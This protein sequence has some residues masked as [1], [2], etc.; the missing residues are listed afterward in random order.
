[1]NGIRTRDRGWLRALNTVE[2]PAGRLVCLPYSGGSAATYRAWPSA[3]PA[4]LSLLAVQYPGHADRLAEPLAGSVAELGAGVAADL[5]RLD[6]APCAL[7]G[8]SL[9]ALVAYEAARVLQEHG[10]PVRALFP[11][12]APAPSQHR[13]GI[14]HEAGEEELWGALC[15]LGGMDPAV[16]RDSELRDLMLPV[17]RA[18]I[19]LSLAYRPAPDAVPLG[20]EVRCHYNTGDPLVDGPR[21]DAW[22]E[23]G[24][25]PFSVRAWP[26]GHFRL[27]SDPAALIGDIVEVL[28]EAGF[29]AGTGVAR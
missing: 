4:D 18:D 27:F 16:A 24:T 28:A 20:C 3:V 2:S 9:G 13:G 7:F 22:A 1:M 26:G 23:V 15:D 12:G 19:A 5:L 8:H 6:P 14:T 10:R 25:G 29:G 21:I 17:L 11:S